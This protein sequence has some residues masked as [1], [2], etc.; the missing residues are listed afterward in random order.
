MMFEFKSHSSYIQVRKENTYNYSDP[1]VN[2]IIDSPI[3]DNV[4]QQF[5]A[6]QYDL[7]QM[8]QDW[9]GIHRAI[10][11]YPAVAQAWVDLQTIKKLCEES[12]E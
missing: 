11:K 9:K 6:M 1:K 5:S 10:E 2:I 8:I 4:C 7:T 12:S 3:I